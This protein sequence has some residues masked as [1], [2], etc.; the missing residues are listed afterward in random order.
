MNNITVEQLLS[1]IEALKQRCPD[2]WKG[3]EV[4]LLYNTEVYHVR[5]IN[6]NYSELALIG[7]TREELEE[8]T[9]F[10]NI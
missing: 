10:H 7:E 3:L 8:R 1:E 5:S 4:T 6:R 9:S 2:S